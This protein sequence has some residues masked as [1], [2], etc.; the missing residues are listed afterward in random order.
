MADSKTRRL[1]PVVLRES[2]E[3]GD[4]IAALGDYKP[5]NDDYT[6]AKIAAARAEMTARQAQETVDFGTYQ[7]S[8]DRATAAEWE[9]NDLIRGAR[10]QVKA[11]YGE[12]SDQLQSVGL[13]KKSEYKAKARKPKPTS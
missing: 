6:Q 3:S 7:A 11:Q 1:S 12:N 9:Y 13:K 4:A 2:I 10:T 5:A 8:R